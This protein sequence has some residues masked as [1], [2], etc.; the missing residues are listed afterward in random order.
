MKEQ[1]EIIKPCSCCGKLI[2]IHTESIDPP[3]TICSH[4]CKNENWLNHS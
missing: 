1:I 4:K 3:F 2:D